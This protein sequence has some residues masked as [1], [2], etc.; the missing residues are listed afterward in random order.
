[1]RPEDLVQ[2]HLADEEVEVVM[3]EVDNADGVVPPLTTGD[4]PDGDDLQLDLGEDVKPDDN[5]SQPPETN[6]QIPPAPPPEDEPVPPPGTSPVPNSHHRR[7]SPQPPSASMTYTRPN[8]LRQTRNA[9]DIARRLAERRALRERQQEQELNFPHPSRS[10]FH[11]QL[12]S[13]SISGR[14]SAYQDFLDRIKPIPKPTSTPLSPDQAMRFPFPSDKYSDGDGGIDS[15]GITFDYDRGSSFQYDRPGSGGP[16]GRGRILRQARAESPE[17]GPATFSGVSDHLALA[18]KDEEKDE[19][20]DN[21]HDDGYENVDERKETQGPETK[22]D[23]FDEVDALIMKF[24]NVGGE[25]LREWA[26]L[27]GRDSLFAVPLRRERDTEEGEDTGEGEG[28]EE[29]AVSQ[30]FDPLVGASY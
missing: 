20:G 16:S 29:K 17:R 21:D 30:V 4:L 6:P 19:E 11:S 5:Q 22:L 27:E 9:D 12:E 18:G 26:G 13:E 23:A 14:P 2:K 8:E 24:T 1:M 10:H 25:E 28:G 7:P 3:P 15:I